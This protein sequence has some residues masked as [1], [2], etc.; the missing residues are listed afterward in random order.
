MRMQSSSCQSWI[1]VW[2][3]GYEDVELIST[4]LVIFLGFWLQGYRANP[5]KVG[6]LSGFL[7]MRMQSSAWILGYEDPELI[8]L[9]L[10]LCLGILDMRM[11][12]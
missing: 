11:Q 3:F 2:V 7:D 8:L 5:V 9:M 10:E 1:F 6:T 12:S 4:K